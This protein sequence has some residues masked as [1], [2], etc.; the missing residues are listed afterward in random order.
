MDDTGAGIEGDVVGE[1]YGCQSIIER[2]L[3]RDALQ[4]LALGG[5]NQLAFKSVC[6]ETF[7]HPFPCQH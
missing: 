7:G 4:C 3:E 1:E 5:A 2:V 6:L